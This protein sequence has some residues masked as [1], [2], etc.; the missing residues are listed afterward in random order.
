MKK[1]LNKSNSIYS[2]VL[3]FILSSCAQQIPPDGGNKDEQAPKVIGEKPASGA[4]NFGANN[5]TINFDEYIQIKEARN[6][7]ISPK[8]KKKPIIQANGK[9]VLIDFIPNSLDSNTTYSISFTNAIADIHEGKLLNTHNYVLS[10]GNNLDSNS[11][12][13]K[14]IDALSQKNLIDVTI[15][16]TDNTQYKDS[17]IY[18]KYISYITKSDSNGNFSLNNLPNKEFEIFAFIDINNNNEIDKEEKIGFLN[19]NI[20]F[21]ITSSSIVLKVFKP[22]EYEPDH[23]IDTIK[24]NERKYQFVIYQKEKANISILDRKISYTTQDIK[25]N[26]GYDTVNLYLSNYQDTSNQ[27]FIY[28]LNN[29]TD[30][31]KIHGKI[32]GKSKRI[33]E[34]KIS[35]I[36]QSK[37][38]DSIIIRSTNPI[39]NIDYQ[40]FTIKKDTLQIDS[41]TWI[42]IDPFNY[43][44]RYKFEP[45]YSYQI[46]VPDSSIT[47]IYN[48]YNTRIAQIITP[49]K[50]ESFGGLKI[51]LPSKI[52]VNLLLEVLD[53]TETKNV[54]YSELINSKSYIIE[55]ITPGKYKIR[56]VKDIN[57]NKKWDTGDYGKQMQPEKIK[58][59]EQEIN[60]KAYW[61]IE[62]ILTENDLL[63]N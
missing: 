52:P 10:T 25:G 12:Q 22:L 56:L 17:S 36:P 18:S 51:E 14:V 11:I 26:N 33:E 58:Y 38:N 53:Q 50:Q 23:L 19:E 2:I 59:I 41:I 42:K 37:P 45:K 61:D 3:F 27:I 48:Q 30:T 49:L 32:K 15:G 34:N 46:I 60:I 13:G 16:L 29:K 6:I 47:S 62:I 43:Y 4:R 39:Q 40:L 24:Q 9:K 20:K 1:I 54:I 21:L 44:L 57:N 28:T 5:I 7:I 8:P 31:L 35:I 63:I 55:N